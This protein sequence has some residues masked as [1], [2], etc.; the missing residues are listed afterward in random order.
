MKIIFFE[1]RVNGLLHRLLPLEISTSEDNRAYSRPAKIEQMANPK[2]I[3]LKEVASC[4]PREV[5]SITGNPD[6]RVP[7][8]VAPEVR[9]P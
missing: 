3:S 1:G 8:A 7:I 4:I 2:N 9:I 6:A 5:W